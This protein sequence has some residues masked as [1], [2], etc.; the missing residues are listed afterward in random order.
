MPT[1]NQTRVYEAMFLVDTGDAGIWDELTKHIEGILGRSGAEL[2]GITRWDERKLAYP[3]GKHKRGTYVLAF[4]HMSSGDGLAEIEHDCRLS[5]KIVRALV[6]KADHFTVADM[7]Q[8]L[9]EDIREDVAKKVM[10][11]RGEKEPPPPEP[12]AGAEGAAETPSTDAAP[13]EVP[14]SD[15]APAEVPTD[16]E[17]AS[18]EPPQAP[19]N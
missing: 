17:A 10:D 18:P 5:D 15:A 7:R 6:L 2:V 13:A 16:A 9:G 12:E 11:A 19:E 14:A 4:F 8:Q 3:V 1:T